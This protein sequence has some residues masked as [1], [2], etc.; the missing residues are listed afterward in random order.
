MSLNKFLNR[1]KC[2]TYFVSYINK[3]CFYKY[4]I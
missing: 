4:N 3:N 2:E 1:N